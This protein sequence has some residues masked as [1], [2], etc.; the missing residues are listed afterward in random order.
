MKIKTIAAMLL[1]S[2]GL[3]FM[4]C[5]S[6]ESKNTAEPTVG[7]AIITGKI[8]AD[9]ILNNG[10]KENVSGVTVVGTIDTRDL[11]TNPVAGANYARK[12]YTATTDANGV[13]TLKVDANV[14][15]VTVSIVIPQTFTAEQTLENGSKVSKLFTRTTFV[16]ATIGV[17]NGQTVTQNADYS[18]EINP[19]LGLAK[20][21]GTAYMRNKMCFSTLDSQITPVTAGT[22][23]VATWTDDNSNA[24]E[25]EITVGADGKF[26]F[27]VE[28]ANASKNV[29][30]KG[31]RF[32][33]K[34]D[35][36]PAPLDPCETNNEYE[37]NH[38]GVNIN[39]TK[40]E[41][42]KALKTDVI[43]Q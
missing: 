24:R 40:N 26:D 39:A 37:Y 43:F 20:I 22:I 9:L 25:V 7:S 11:V 42:T 34:R 5:T 35:S 15:P 10:Q 28:T 8:T 36:R 29:N 33:G 16:P 23:L 19:A 4:S 12:S 21:T 13:Y 32:V 3:T 27:V 38:G 2:T 14:K 1:V 41:T 30:I 31:R 6:E 17:N 18:Y